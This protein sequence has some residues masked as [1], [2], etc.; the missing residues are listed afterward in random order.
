M[1][2]VCSIEGCNR[3]RKYVET[4]W[5]QTHYHRY[6]RTG[7]VELV[8]KELRADLT[9]YGAH[10]RVK[11]FFGS[12]TKYLCISCGASADEWSY[13]GTDPSELEGMVSLS[14]TVFPVTYSVWPE[15]YAPL[16]I[17]CHRKKERGDT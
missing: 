15:F 4:G 1:G 17:P 2:D 6:W 8:P 7:S 16:C 12:A 10:G 11:A 3:E 9:Y 14:G 5:C 13:D